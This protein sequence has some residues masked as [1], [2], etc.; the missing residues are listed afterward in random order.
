[1]SQTNQ[2]NPYYSADG[3]ALVPPAEQPWKPAAEQETAQ[4]TVWLNPTDKDAV[5]DLYVGT[6]PARTQRA[7]EA[8]KALPRP[9]QRELQTGLRRFIIR[10]GHRRSISSDFDMAIQQTHCQETECMTRP[11][12][13]RDPSHHKM[14]IGGFGPQLVNE[15]V[16]H[17]PIVH[18]A[19]I[20]AHAREQAA[21]AAATEAL[22]QKAVAEAALAVASAEVMKQTQIRETARMTQ[23]QADVEKRQAIAAKANTKKE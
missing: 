20:E 3:R 19:L 2:E 7:R 14:V 22:H 23:E 13:C 12:Y 5:L 4:E 15:A 6:T 21:L 9:Q 8:R 11:M 17:R 18:P 16:Q 10:A 1:M